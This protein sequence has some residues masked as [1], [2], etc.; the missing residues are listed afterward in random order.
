[1]GPLDS[2]STRAVAPGGEELDALLGNDGRQ[3]LPM[4]FPAR[5]YWRDIPRAAELLEIDCFDPSS[6]ARG[7]RVIPSDRMQWIGTKT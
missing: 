2:E 1:M 4:M 6:S 5:P 3:C 7:S